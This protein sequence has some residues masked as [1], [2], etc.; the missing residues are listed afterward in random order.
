MKKLVKDFRVF[1]D[2]NEDGT[3]D[4]ISVNYQISI[5]NSKVENVFNEYG[6]SIIK[7]SETFEHFVNK[8]NGH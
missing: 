7:T 2:E 8:Y 5:V 4:Q 1:K 3:I 6:Y